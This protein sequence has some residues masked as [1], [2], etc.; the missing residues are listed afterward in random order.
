MS[1]Y[2]CFGA[3]LSGSSVALR[4]LCCP[5]C[6]TSHHLGSSSASAAEISSEQ[7]DLQFWL[8]RRLLSPPGLPPAP[9][10]SGWD[11]VG[12][13]GAWLGSWTAPTAGTLRTVRCHAQQGKAGKETEKWG[14]RYENACPS[15]QLLHVCCALLPETW[16]NIACWWE[17]ENYCFFP[18]SFLLCGLC[19]FSSFFSL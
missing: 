9:R 6:S 8:G 19:L 1:Y 10:G 12:L 11:P 16:P 17:A 3:Q 7:D 14:S 5:V 18:V 13:Q 4:V 2:S 15:K